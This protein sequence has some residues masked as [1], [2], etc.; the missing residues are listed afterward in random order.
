VSLY[1]KSLP[2]AYAAFR[3][4]EQSV[5][6]GEFAPMIEPTGGSDMLVLLRRLR[7]GDRGS[8]ELFTNRIYDRLVRLTRLIL[9]NGSTR[10][11]RWEE[12]DDLVHSAW[13]RIQRALQTE[14]L[15]FKQPEHIFRIAAQHIRF[16]MIDMH[17]RHRARALT[18]Q[19]EP[20]F[21]DDHR[22]QEDRRFETGSSID[23]RQ[24]AHWEDFHAA[25]E[26][27]PEPLKEVMDLVW[28]QGFSQEEVAQWLNLS[29]RSIKRR[30]REAKL[31]LAEELDV[32]MLD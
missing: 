11:Q 32:G 28:Y 2:G 21:G 25:V 30:W 15:T 23:P 19:T 8:L 10:V 17:R 3:L 12:T 5:P 27:L 7:E 6:E 26:K 4:I 24:V 18:H 14:S 9:H 1:Q 20:R 13:I 16:E 22:A 29:V 31:R